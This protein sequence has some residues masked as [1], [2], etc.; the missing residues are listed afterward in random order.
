MSDHSANYPEITGPGFDIRA[1]ER[2]YQR[3]DARS[4]R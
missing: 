4:E 2:M 1:I 3:M